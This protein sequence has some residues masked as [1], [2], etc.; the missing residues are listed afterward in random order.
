M[1]REAAAAGRFYPGTRA[2][3]NSMVERMLSGGGPRRRAIGV[4]CPHAGYMY[5]GRVAGAVYSSVEI[6]RKVVL[7]GPNHSGLGPQFSLMTEGE[8]ELPNGVLP[9]DSALAGRVAEKVPFFTSDDAAHV[10]EYSIEVQLPFIA[11][12]RPDALIVPIAMEHALLDY[13]RKAAE[14]LAKAVEEDGGNALIIASSDMSHYLPEE[15]A[16]KKDAVAIGHMLKLDPAGLFNAVMDEQI[17]MCGTAAVVTMLYAAILLGASEARL[18]AYATSGDVTGDR[19]Q[20]VG[21]A[22]IIIS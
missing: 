2:G 3:L 11:H 14:G 17:S 4:M 5:S 13:L 1:I 22:G 10:E 12:L 20:V 16:K 15:T 7:L 9:V 18:A 6:P 19:A 21:Y 8:W